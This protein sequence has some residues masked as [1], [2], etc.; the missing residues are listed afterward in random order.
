MFTNKHNS[1]KT[2]VLD[3]IDIFINQSDQSCFSEFVQNQ[4]LSKI[5]QG[6]KDES[7]QFRMKIAIMMSNTIN[8][9]SE[10]ELKMLEMEQILKLITS[11]LEAKV[12][13][14]ALSVI[15]KNMQAF[16][17]KL[18]DNSEYA[19]MMKDLQTFKKIE[20][21]QNDKNSEVSAISKQLFDQS[22]ARN[23]YK[24]YGKID[25]TNVNLK[26]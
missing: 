24:V 26:F 19:R 5:M 3:I 18:D 6:S 22:S 20:D 17:N 12:D 1:F 14:R 2:K 16:M 23:P 9:C 7:Q 15:I 11:F 21:L 4:Y 10:D 13:S 8:R 25:M